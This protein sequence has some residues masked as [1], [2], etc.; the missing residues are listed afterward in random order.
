MAMSGLDTHPEY[1]PTEARVQTDASDE[2]RRLGE[3]RIHDMDSENRRREESRMRMRVSDPD[4]DSERN[5]P[6]QIRTDSDRLIGWRT[7]SDGD[8]K[9]PTRI[10]Q[11]VRGP[12]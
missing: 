8:S 6:M 3:T 4:G 12:R 11:W 5:L 7:D 10:S 2:D 9:G 1:G